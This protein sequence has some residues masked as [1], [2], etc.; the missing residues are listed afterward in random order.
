MSKKIVGK[1]AALL[2]VTLLFTMDSAWAAEKLETVFWNLD[3]AA[4][5]NQVKQTMAQQQFVV[6]D[7]GKDAE[8]R[9]LLFDKGVFMGQPT[10]V[11][12]RWPAVFSESDSKMIQD[13]AVVFATKGVGTEYI[14]QQTADRLQVKFGEPISKSNYWMK[15]YPPVRVDSVI[16]RVTDLRGAFYDVTLARVGTEKVSGE[17]PSDSEVQLMIER[18]TLRSQNETKRTWA[19]R[20]PAPSLIGPGAEGTPPDTPVGITPTM[21]YERVGSLSYVYIFEA[22]DQYVTLVEQMTQ[23]ANPVL[24]ARVTADSFTVPEGV[25]LPGHSYRWR[26]ESIHAAGT[27]SEATKNSVTFY[28][29]T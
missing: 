17:I 3:W 4:S 12:I 9:W 20:F 25:L 19:N 28:F 16:W 10:Q 14:F 11:K 27:K 1:L 5:E 18:D 13:V 29:N 7:R 2:L 8:S 15:S 22:Q 24:V 6:I 26:V 23:Q 21:Q